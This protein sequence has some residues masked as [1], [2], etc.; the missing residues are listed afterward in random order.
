MAFLLPVFKGLFVGSSLLFQG[1][2]SH[3]TEGR[4]EM[5]KS[6]QRISL[7]KSTREQR[8]NLSHLISVFVSY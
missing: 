2:I 1:L 6:D 5:N 4:K 3:I 8:V 7:A